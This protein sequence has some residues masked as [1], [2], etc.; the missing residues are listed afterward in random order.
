M[1]MEGRG[2][3]NRLLFDLSHCSRDGMQAIWLADWHIHQLS[4]LHLILAF[5]RDLYTIFHSSHINLHSQ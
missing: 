5:L 2:T 4:C 1:R 3:W